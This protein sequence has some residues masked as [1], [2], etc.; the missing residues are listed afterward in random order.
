MQLTPKPLTTDAFAPYGEVVDIHSANKEFSMNYG[1][2]TRY[3]DL[4]E[5][6]VEDKGGKTCISLV[7]SNAVTFPFKVDKMEYHPY[8]SQM[9]YP[10]CESPFLILVA[11]PA[12][13]LDTKKLE[14]FI[15]D[16]KQ[17]VNYHKGVWHHYL[18]PLNNESQ[19]MVVDRNGNDENCI[20]KQ[21][22]EDII[23]ALQ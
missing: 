8:G 3:F 11:K 15:S 7:K 17:G 2:A 19:F 21:I 9:F 16:G 20:E 10:L 14:L 6:D 5:I 13:T 18:M 12:E 4:A 1:L 22:E 23:L